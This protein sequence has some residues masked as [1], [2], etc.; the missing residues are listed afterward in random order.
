MLT[1]QIAG[2]ARCIQ[3]LFVS[4]C[5]RVVGILIVLLAIDSVVV[6]MIVVAKHGFCL[7]TLQYIGQRTKVILYDARGKHLALLVA[8]IARY[9]GRHLCHRV[10][11]QVQAIVVEHGA[12]LIGIGWE[13]HALSPIVTYNVG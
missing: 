8:T 5:G 7:Q 10:L 4:L 13:E 2:R 1:S 9:V 6:Q 12:R 3:L 11:L